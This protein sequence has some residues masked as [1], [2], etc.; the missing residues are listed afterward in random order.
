MSNLRGDTMS[1]LPSKNSSKKNQTKYFGVAQ[2]CKFCKLVLTYLV[3]YITLFVVLA[4]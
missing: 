4:F 3:L 2:V 1:S